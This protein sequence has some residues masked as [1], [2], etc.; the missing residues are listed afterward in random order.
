MDKICNMK[1][2]MNRIIKND[3]DSL[4]KRI[5][6]SFAATIRMFTNQ[7]IEFGLFQ[8]T[9]KNKKSNNKGLGISK[10]KLS[11]PDDFNDYDK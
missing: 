4:F 3:I 1:V 7:S 8:F 5:G 6:K 11:L 10:G 9:I 2:R